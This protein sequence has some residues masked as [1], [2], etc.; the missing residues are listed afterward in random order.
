MDAAERFARPMYSYAEADRIAGVTRGTSKR[1]ARGYSYLSNGA[2]VSAAPV[3]KGVMQPGE[4]GV[5][6]FDLIEVA[7]IGRLKEI[8]WSLRAIR[9]AVESCQALLNLQRPLVTERFKSDGRDFFVQSEGE[10][11]ELGIGRRKGERAWTE[12]LDPFLKTVAYEGEFV[13]RWWPIGQHRHVIVDPEYGFGLPVVAGS[14]VRTEII[15][16]QVQGFVPQQRIAD[17]FNITLEDV[18]HAIQFEASRTLS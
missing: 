5:S 2:R 7:V 17:D 8:G 12:V 10:L 6:F 11:I 13:R 15:Y 14:G 9:A 4:P 3:T 16:E 18:E 1:W